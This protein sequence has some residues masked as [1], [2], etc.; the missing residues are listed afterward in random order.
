MRGVETYTPAFSIQTKSTC[1][2]RGIT[3]SSSQGGTTTEMRGRT[4]WIAF[5]SGSFGIIVK[6]RK[7]PYSWICL[8]MGVVNA[9]PFGRG[10]LLKKALKAFHDSNK[11]CA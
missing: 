9:P 2:S 1:L 7:G 8:G 11:Q 6:S 10:G 5:G 3:A 4:V